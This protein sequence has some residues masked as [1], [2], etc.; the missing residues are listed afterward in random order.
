MCGAAAGLHQT[1]HPHSFVKCC[2]YMFCNVYFMFKGADIIFFSG[3][4]MFLVVGF[5][6]YQGCFMLSYMNSSY[7]LKI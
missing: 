3:H 7:F 5:M 6:Y 1:F 2:Y 4:L